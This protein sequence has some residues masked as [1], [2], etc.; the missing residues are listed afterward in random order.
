MDEEVV[1]T[2]EGLINSQASME[3]ISDTILS[4]RRIEFDTRKEV[5]RN[6]FLGKLYLDERNRVA[7]NNLYWFNGRKAWIYSWIDRGWVEYKW[8]PSYFNFQLPV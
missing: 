3:S 1:L 8:P 6:S 4:D 7:V 5:R 2:Y